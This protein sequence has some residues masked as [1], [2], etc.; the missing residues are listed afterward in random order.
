MIVK[1]ET[2]TWRRKAPGGFPPVLELEG[3][4]A[5]RRAGPELP[6]E[7]RDLMQIGEG[8]SVVLST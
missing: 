2:A 7:V 8:G 1:P 4:Q 5:V 6:K 3:P